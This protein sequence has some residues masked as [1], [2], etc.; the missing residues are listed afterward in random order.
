ME[1][2]DLTPYV[3]IV[4]AF[5]T[6]RH[7]DASKLIEEIV[8]TGSNQGENVARLHMACSLNHVPI[9]DGERPFLRFSIP[10]LFELE[11]NVLYDESADN[12]DDVERKI[13]G[14]VAEVLEY[15]L[16][17][18]LL[19]K[20]NLINGLFWP[21]HPMLDA[22][23][24]RAF[25]NSSSFVCSEMTACN[26]PPD[27]ATRLSYIEK[28]DTTFLEWA[29][30]SL[31][32]GDTSGCMWIGEEYSMMLGV[33]QGFVNPGHAHY[34]LNSPI[35]EMLFP[36]RK[37][38]IVPITEFNSALLHLANH[39]LNPSFSLHAAGPIGLASE[40]Y[41]NV[42]PMKANA[43]T[44]YLADTIA[45][46][47]SCSLRV[48]NLSE[49]SDEAVIE[50]SS[51]NEN[52]QFCE[53]VHFRIMHLG[54]IPIN[55]LLVFNA[56]EEVVA[57]LNQEDMHIEDIEISGTLGNILAFAFGDDPVKILLDSL[58]EES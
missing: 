16:P 1:T 11:S 19:G 29:V 7:L 22:S 25:F 50:I 34:L 32:R 37:E 41:M 6:G 2:I 24:V 42:L 47:S 3:P 36:N 38:A 17:E 31:V 57:V 44:L 39:R 45:E 27:R 20:I 28:G 23:H 54:C 55:P 51:S 35:S 4:H 10:L 5:H 46:G 33:V 8:Q 56:L 12:F 52:D 9:L 14:C 18:E 15:A 40:T 58:R 53:G 26:E 49:S 21:S 43:A 13:V 30:G 48:D